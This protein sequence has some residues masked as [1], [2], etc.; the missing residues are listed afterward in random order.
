MWISLAL[1]SVSDRLCMDNSPGEYFNFAQAMEKLNAVVLPL[2]RTL[3]DAAAARS[4]TATTA[5]QE[6]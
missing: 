2:A 1:K 5:K 6:D 3:R 4:T